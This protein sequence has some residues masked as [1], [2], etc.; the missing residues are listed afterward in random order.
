MDSQNNSPGLESVSSIPSFSSTNSPFA[1]PANRG[2]R[3]MAPVP[4][5]DLDE[6]MGQPPPDLEEKK[7]ETN[8][9]QVEMHDPPMFR[10]AETLPS[11]LPAT[12]FYRGVEDTDVETLLSRMKVSLS[13]VRKK[14]P[15][16]DRVPDYPWLPP[17]TPSDPSST[18]GT[19]DTWPPTDRQFAVFNTEFMWTHD[20][21]LPHFKSARNFY[22]LRQQL[23]HFI[24]TRLIPIRTLKFTSLL[25]EVPK[26]TLDTHIRRSLLAEHGATY[27]SDYFYQDFYEPVFLSSHLDTADILTYCQFYV[28]E[29]MKVMKQDRLANTNR[30]SSSTM[31]YLLSKAMDEMEALDVA[32][33][34][35]FMM[36]WMARLVIHR[37]LF[38]SCDKWRSGTGSKTELR[39]KFM[40]DMRLVERFMAAPHPLPKIPS[41]HYKAS[42]FLPETAKVFTR[43]DLCRLVAQ[44]ITFLKLTPYEDTPWSFM[45]EPVV[46][47][48]DASLF[49]YA[50]FCWDLLR[51]WVTYVF[52]TSHFDFIDPFLEE[53]GHDDLF[54]EFLKEWTGSRY[55]AFNAYVPLQLT[56]SAQPFP[57]DAL[58]LRRFETTLSDPNGTRDATVLY[59]NNR[60]S[61]IPETII[62]GPRIGALWGFENEALPGHGG[63]PSSK[64][65]AK[66]VGAIPTP[67]EA[68]T[69]LNACMSRLWRLVFFRASEPSN[70]E[71]TADDGRHFL[72]SV[73]EKDLLLKLVWSPYLPARYRYLLYSYFD[74]LASPK[75]PARAIPYTLV[76]NPYDTPYLD[77]AAASNLISALR[78][79]PLACESSI[80]SSARQNVREVLDNVRM[81]ING[82]K[83]VYISSSQWINTNKSKAMVTLDQLYDRVVSPGDDPTF[84]SFLYYIGKY[85]SLDAESLQGDV[86]TSVWPRSFYKQVSK[87]L[88][89]NLN[90]DRWEQVHAYSPGPTPLEWRAFLFCAFT[91]KLPRL[92]V[93]NGNSDSLD[94][95]SSV[96]K[97]VFG[98]SF[99]METKLKTTLHYAVPI[100]RQKT[101]EV[102]ADA[103]LP[104]EAIIPLHVLQ[105]KHQRENQNLV[106][107][108]TIYGAYKKCTLSECAAYNVETSHGLFSDLISSIRIMDARG[109]GYAKK[110]RD[111]DAEFRVH[112]GSMN[113]LSLIMSVT[114]KMVDYHLLGQT[115]LTRKAFLVSNATLNDWKTI[116]WGHDARVVWNPFQNSIQA[117][118]SMPS[119]TPI[120]SNE[121][122]P[123]ILGA[124]LAVRDAS[125]LN[126]GFLSS[127]LDPDRVFISP[128]DDMVY[129]N[130]E[131]AKLEKTTSDIDLLAEVLE[132][133]AISKRVL[134]FS[135][136]LPIDAKSVSLYLLANT[137]TFFLERL[138]ALLDVHLKHFMQEGK[139]PSNWSTVFSPVLFAFHAWDYGIKD[140]FQRS[141]ISPLLPFYEQS[142]LSARFSIQ[143]KK[144]A[145]L[146]LVKASIRSFMKAAQ[147]SLG[148][149]F[150]LHEA[151]EYQIETQIQQVE[152]WK[153]M[154]WPYLKYIHVKEVGY[155]AFLDDESLKAFHFPKSTAHLKFADPGK[156][157]YFTSGFE[158]HRYNTKRFNALAI[159]FATLWTLVSKF[160]SVNEK[161]RFRRSNSFFYVHMDLA[162]YTGLSFPFYK[163][164]WRQP[165]GEV[166]QKH[167]VLYRTTV[168]YIFG[169]QGRPM[170]QGTTSLTITTFFMK[171]I[172]P[173]PSPLK[174]AMNQLYLNRAS[175]WTAISDRMDKGQIQTLSFEEVWLDPIPVFVRI[176][177]RGRW[178]PSFDY[179]FGETAIGD[180][181]H[182][183]DRRHSPVLSLL[184]KD[185]Y[186]LNPGDRAYKDIQEQTRRCF[187]H[188]KYVRISLSYQ[189]RHDY[190]SWMTREEMETDNTYLRMFQG[191]ETTHLELHL[192]HQWT[193]VPSFFPFHLRTQFPQLRTLKLCITLKQGAHEQELEPLE[194]QAFW[195]EG[196][197]HLHVEAHL[198]NLVEET[199]ERRS[200]ELD[201]DF[202]ED[203]VYTEAIVKPGTWFLPLPKHLVSF[204]LTWFNAFQLRFFRKWGVDK[205]DP[206]RDIS[207]LSEA[208]TSV[209]TPGL[210]GQPFFSGYQSCSPY[211]LRTQQSQGTLNVHNQNPSLHYLAIRPCLH[212]KEIPLFKELKGFIAM[213]VYLEANDVLFSHEYQPVDI[214]PIPDIYKSRMHIHFHHSLYEKKGDQAQP[215]LEEKREKTQEEDAL[216]PPS[217]TQ[218]ILTS[219]F[220]NGTPTVDCEI[221]KEGVDQINPTRLKYTVKP[222]FAL[223]QQIHLKR[224]LCLFDFGY[225]YPD[226]VDQDRL[227]RLEREREQE[228]ESEDEEEEEDVD[229]EQDQLFD[230]RDR[231]EERLEARLAAR[232]A[233]RRAA[234][235][236]EEEA[237]PPAPLPRNLGRHR[238]ILMPSSENEYDDEEEE[239]KK[240]MPAPEEPMVDTG[241]ERT[242]SVLSSAPT[243]VMTQ[244]PTLEESIDAIYVEPL[245]EPSRGP[246][247][248]QGAVV[249]L[250]TTYFPPQAT[251][252]GLRFNVGQRDLDGPG[253]PE[254]DPAVFQT[255]NP[256]KLMFGKH[257]SWPRTLEYLEWSVFAN[258]TFIKLT[259]AYRPD[260]EEPQVYWDRR[261]D[262]NA[263]RV[264]F[265][266]RLFRA[267]W[268]K[269]P[270]LKTLVLGF[271]HLRRRQAL[272][273]VFSIPAR[274]PLST[275]ILVPIQGVLKAQDPGL[276]D[277]DMEQ[278]A[279]QCGYRH[280]GPHVGFLTQ[281]EIV[282]MNIGPILE[283][284]EKTL[285]KESSHNFPFPNSR[286]SKFMPTS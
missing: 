132:R 58:L 55:E 178:P 83:G 281:E 183:R 155:P 114:F 99:Y 37:V 36:M 31:D 218:L 112:V 192:V 171:G 185:L 202:P 119:A 35:K 62:A 120:N 236:E 161:Y 248:P 256:A 6:D 222:L 32:L 249:F 29:C 137:F 165:I 133:K 59:R 10:P 160:L 129:I 103:M 108:A 223:D 123:D 66:L 272:W 115:T 33:E 97:A 124:A 116:A 270:A 240:E 78:F 260:R 85:V 138:K 152:T 71:K 211:V 26:A 197:E 219:R 254:E 74:F 214:E 173:S 261:P 64:P 24:D 172:L 148:A 1:T 38:A 166:E 283:K 253:H 92:Q 17:W 41:V 238:I 65:I 47:P 100:E 257:F 232:R 131:K 167:Y 250:D 98:A 40:V 198:H 89:G 84:V 45:R 229:V 210:F 264:V 226:D 269:P 242:Q 186:G 125:L 30:R 12:R 228:E 135:L 126:A 284:G 205:V 88:Y 118:R 157:L 34:A 16:N 175:D 95:T 9:E 14:D 77:F 122:N 22:L 266:N 164:L 262:V 18:K 39:R 136:Y 151:L 11:F 263:L 79:Y 212:W 154:A 56:Y 215:R 255:L 134:Q 25:M 2:T 128:E 109:R 206:T 244:D 49:P 279:K 68:M 46:D 227:A 193:Q 50:Y 237:P 247:H 216:W 113:K 20:T 3:P 180:Y 187:L 144:G 177:K 73:K 86:R 243:V 80:R 53:H 150:Y 271:Y 217:L 230:F 200:Y 163:D 169:V 23:A 140:S 280:V 199:I 241:L 75:T 81:E 127:D 234:G 176:T 21:T 107:P 158:R 102:E 168:P 189:R 121:P 147:S 162:T 153:K 159:Q 69:A 19:T 221:T 184:Q 28:Y 239:E 76:A 87:D 117:Y 61:G 274:S 51:V 278:Y 181:A 60:Y 225:H 110:I 251:H 196:L 245:D 188:A 201:N 145:L 67:L 195:P 224:V 208:D 194:D 52:D 48:L 268:P 275:G 105:T 233:E 72:L 143:V 13:H 220:L 82:E 139:L 182:A 267:S 191:L 259:D 42:W 106:L 149:R 265:P 141:K 91:S 258:D 70:R 273:K 54:M 93:V 57:T 203:L 156:T 63:P 4:P 276:L 8:E 130:D 7:E 277:K 252:I 246:E 204:Q 43:G 235:E 90:E 5:L 190:T 170:P 146:P 174:V 179:P 27:L 207:Y 286:L 94:K 111:T 44:E 104:F 15:N 231:E 285:L 213:D 96:P 101:R 142:V 209:S 282:G